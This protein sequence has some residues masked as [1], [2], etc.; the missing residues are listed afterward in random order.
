MT[1]R[2]RSDDPASSTVTVR[3]RPAE[4]AALLTCAETAGVRPSRIVRRMIREL[5]TAGPD[6]FGDGLK[7]INATHRELAAIGRNLNQLLKLAHRGEHL[8]AWE[9]RDELRDVAGQVEAVRAV[10][11]SA[12]EQSRKRTVAYVADD[13]GGPA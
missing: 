10:Y 3:L 11:R 4:K 5:V 8:T 13:D 2:P 7:E 6:Y 9:L 12:V 1:G